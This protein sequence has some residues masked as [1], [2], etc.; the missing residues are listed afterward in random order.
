MQARNHGKVLLTGA[1]V[2]QEELRTSGIRFHYSHQKTEGQLIA[3]GKK[4]MLS[5]KIISKQ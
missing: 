5:Y 2:Y 1:V 4:N 3:A